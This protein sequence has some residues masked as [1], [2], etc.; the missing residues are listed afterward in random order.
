[1][2]LFECPQLTDLSPLAKVKSLEQ[3]TLGLFAMNATELRPLAE[4]PQLR[5]LSLM[6]HGAFDLTA[7]AGRQDM[8]VTIPLGASITGAENLGPGCTVTE[9][10]YASSA[11]PE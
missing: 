1:M 5:R 4:L 6:G 11:A 3:V 7:L 8:A 9:S 10:D 2:E